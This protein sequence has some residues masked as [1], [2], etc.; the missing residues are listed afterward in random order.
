[1][2]EPQ[3][4]LSAPADEAVATHL[5]SPASAAGPATTPSATPSPSATAS[6]AA[7]VSKVDL[8]LGRDVVRGLTE[9]M[10]HYRVLS[11]SLQR[12]G[13]VSN[14]HHQGNVL[15]C[16]CA[17]TSAGYVLASERTP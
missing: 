15:S 10:I 11:M 7:E 2:Q 1:M 6:G 8:Q 5:V 13:F 3:R 17:L 16:S 14:N 9:V 12:G 4:H